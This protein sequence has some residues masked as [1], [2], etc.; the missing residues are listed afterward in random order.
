L[1][2]RKTNAWFRVG[3]LGYYYDIKDMSKA[4]ATLQSDEVKFAVN[5]TGITEIEEI[6]A[7][8]NMEEL[9]VVAKE[10]KSGGGNKSQLVASLKRSNS[11]QGRLAEEGQLKLRYDDKG[12]K[13]NRN[14]LYMK[15]LLDISGKLTSSIIGIKLMG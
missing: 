10:A 11:N 6:A 5:E 13:E 12:N 9:K 14:A 15:K 1:F 8:L 3:K 7:L 4:C 2:L